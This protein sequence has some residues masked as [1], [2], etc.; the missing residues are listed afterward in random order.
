MLGALMKQ[1][2][3]IACQQ[4]YLKNSVLLFAPVIL[5]G[6]QEQCSRSEW[7]HLFPSWTGIAIMMCFQHLFVF[8]LF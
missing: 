3:S 6:M 1:F 5:N 2:E 4:E 8:H 7:K